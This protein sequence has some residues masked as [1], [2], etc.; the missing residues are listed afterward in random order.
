MIKFKEFLVFTISR[1]GGLLFIYACILQLVWS[2]LILYSPQALLVTP[3]LGLT[4]LIGINHIFVSSI[5]FFTDLAAIYFLA[6]KDLK[7][8]NFIYLIPQQIIL[9]LSA[10]GC[11]QAVILGHYADGVVRSHLFILADQLPNILIAFLYTI[12]ILGWFNTRREN[13]I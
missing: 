8:S 6:K 7:A 2:V 1:P 10:F 9:L 3:L 12:A 4:Q 13:N 11:L 5:L